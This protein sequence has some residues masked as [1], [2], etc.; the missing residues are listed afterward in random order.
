MQEATVVAVFA[1]RSNDGPLG[2]NP[3][4][5]RVAASHI[6]VRR[7]MGQRGELD[8]ARIASDIAA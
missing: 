2:N 3:A 6:A 4:D 8:A 1:L 7:T 5:A